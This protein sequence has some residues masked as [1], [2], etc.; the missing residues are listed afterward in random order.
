M[1]LR[2]NGTHVRIYGAV[3]MHNWSAS[4]DPNYHIQVTTLPK[5]S[6]ILKNS[7]KVLPKL[8]RSSLKV[9]IESIS[10]TYMKEVTL[11]NKSL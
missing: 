11:I 3:N 10:K 4:K 9:K 7:I 2:K 8:K 6:A 1:F 5:F